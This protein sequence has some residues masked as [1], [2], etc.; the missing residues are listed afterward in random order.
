M[1]DV[2]EYAAMEGD[3]THA[4]WNP[5][6]EEV[7]YKLIKQATDLAG[8]IAVEKGEAVLIKPNFVLSFYPMQYRGHGDDNSIQANI[9][10]PRACLAVARICKKKGARRIIIADC[11]ALGDAWATHQN[12]GLV[13]AQKRYAEMGIKFEL[14]DLCE[15]PEMMAG[16]PSNIPCPSC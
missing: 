2:I 16:P 6:S 5:A 7:W 9:A 4:N 10:D 14:I 11:P 8:G 12:Y 13:H 1:K 3:F 15:N